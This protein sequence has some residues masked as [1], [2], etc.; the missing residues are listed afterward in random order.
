[1]IFVGTARL[2]A[3]KIAHCVC[4]ISVLFAIQ[5]REFGFERLIGCKLPHQTG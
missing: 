5:A 4:A 2:L 3:F 1:M